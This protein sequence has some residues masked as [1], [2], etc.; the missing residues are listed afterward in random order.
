MAGSEVP[1]AKDC[2]PKR[3]T[4]SL[5]EIKEK[6][7]HAHTTSPGYLIHT[8]EGQIF[9]YSVYVSEI[10]LHYSEPPGSFSGLHIQMSVVSGGL[11]MTKAEH[12][13]A[14]SPFPRALVAHLPPPSSRPTFE[15]SVF[16]FF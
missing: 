2:N 3:N 9:I 7:R 13:P 15:L 8:Q 14:P 16:L 5:C 6:K 1:L 11:G 10:V 4:R 12:P